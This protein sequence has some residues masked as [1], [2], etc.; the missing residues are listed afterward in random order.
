LLEQLDRY[1]WQTQ[2]VP[3]IP[4]LKAMLGSS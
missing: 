3:T 4:M 1:A 2:R